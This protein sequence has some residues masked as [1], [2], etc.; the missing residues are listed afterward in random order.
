M[1]A[2]FHINL[3]T[4]VVPK[5]VLVFWSQKIMIIIR[6]T[7]T[8]QLIS[9]FCRVNEK[10]QNVAQTASFRTQKA[11]LLFWTWITLCDTAQHSCLLFVPKNNQINLVLA[12]ALTFSLVMQAFLQC[13]SMFSSLGM[14]FN[15]CECVCVSAINTIT[16]IQH[17][18]W[19]SFVKA[20]TKGLNIIWILLLTSNIV[21]QTWVLVTVSWW[22]SCSS[23][24]WIPRPPWWPGVTRPTSRA[25]AACSPFTWWPWGWGVCV[26]RRASTWSQW[27][28]NMYDVWWQRSTW[29]VGIRTKECRNY[30]LF[31]LS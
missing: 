29:W 19:V 12:L 28:V 20:S 25:L 16:Q 1:P 21:S 11:L 2:W 31:N 8:C 6:L 9:H 30:H 7:G 4:A 26:R 23:G 22:A 5:L 3:S 10:K 18:G 15:C 24:T 13:L 27:S 14:T 17:L